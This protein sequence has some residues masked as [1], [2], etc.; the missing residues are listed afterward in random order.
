[1]LFLQT[2]SGKKEQK[3][4][5]IKQK[6]LIINAIFFSVNFQCIAKVLEALVSVI[7]IFCCFAPILNLFG[8][9]QQKHRE[10]DLRSLLP[11][12]RIY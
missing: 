10:V 7:M 2:K 4:L 3:L 12:F 6:V 9:M 11:L 1:M 8:K 5:V